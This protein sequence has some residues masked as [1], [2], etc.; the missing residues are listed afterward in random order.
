MPFHHK[1]VLKVVGVVGFAPTQPEGTGFTD[2]LGSLTPTHTP[3]IGRGNGN[4]MAHLCAI[5]RL[6]PEEETGDCMA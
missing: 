1:P 4:A 2:Q 3:Q 5:Y 6:F